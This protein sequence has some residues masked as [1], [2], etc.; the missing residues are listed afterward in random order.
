MGM[1]K[2]ITVHGTFAADKS[3]SGDAW[4]QRDSAFTSALLRRLEISDENYVIEPFHWDGANSELS[5]RKWGK[6]LYNR[7]KSLEEAKEP[8][9]LVGHSHG[10]AVIMEALRESNRKGIRLEA[11]QSIVTVGTPFLEFVSPLL[12]RILRLMTSIIYGALLFLP[13][14]VGILFLAFQMSERPGD[15]SL[16]TL[17]DFLN[18][19]L[20]TSQ[21][22]VYFL[23][24]EIFVMT[25][26]IVIAA[27]RLPGV[28]RIVWRHQRAGGSTSLFDWY[29]D[30]W[31]GLHDREDEAVNVL[32]ASRRSPTKLVP[33]DLVAGPLGYS[34][35]LITFVPALLFFMF[36]AVDTLRYREVFENLD[37]TIQGMIPV[38]SIIAVLVGAIGYLIFHRA[39]LPG[40]RFISSWTV[41]WPFAAVADRFVWSIV[42]ARAFGRDIGS[43]K[44]R[45][46]R[47]FPHEFKSGWRPLP[48]SYHEEIKGHV[49]QYSNEIMARV[50]GLLGR[51]HESGGGFSL[52]ESIGEELTGR[53]LIHTAYFDIPRTTDYVAYQ[54]LIGDGALE[55]DSPVREEWIRYSQSNI[56]DM[57]PVRPEAGAEKSD[58][59]SQ[60][61]LAAFVVLVGLGGVA[62]WQL[63]EPETPISDP[64]SELRIGSW[65]RDCED[66]PDLVVVPRELALQKG[67]IPPATKADPRDPIA[68]G[69]FEVSIEQWMSCI[70]A[71]S[72]S[73]ARYERGW[74]RTF[75]NKLLPASW[76]ETCVRTGGC[77]VVRG[78]EPQ[79]SKPGVVPDSVHRKSINSVAISRDGRFVVTGSDDKT[80]RIWDL[81][82]GLTVQ[83]FGDKGQ[84]HAKR[85]QS[86]AISTDGRFVITGSSDKTA[87]VWEVQTGQ[88]VQTFGGEGLGHVD[89]INSVAISRDSRYV[90]T[91]SDDRTARM[92]DVQTGETV[93][94]FGGDSQGHE[95]WG[96]S[97]V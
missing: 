64:T 79:L 10:G 74:F 54:I 94:I 90:V 38:G 55:I 85:I 44:L 82:T 69:I 33:R 50:R 26:A 70:K 48:D 34:L 56:T 87:R 41:S 32:S 81:Q 92:W 65:L 30:K 93:Q 58:R 39:I 68:V 5:R 73:A 78:M 7:L 1:V 35:A 16:Q 91:G 9:H 61:L 80:A 76:I 53:E 18:F 21:L 11:L 63:L 29:A 83:T 47:T 31:V 46:V 43:I 59:R 2:I 72:C 86:V 13:I 25:S 67:Q 88:T 28:F 97:V 22:D 77:G 19:S 4:W 23:C 42:N 6:R 8:Y 52:T 84:G 17:S 57:R 37:Y 62:N 49:S 89:A 75:A 15:L 66:C 71:G 14:V 20:R 96:K 60:I 95:R 36:F 3:D 24:V 40:F 12:G 45:R 27:R 51:F